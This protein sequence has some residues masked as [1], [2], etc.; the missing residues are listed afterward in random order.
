MIDQDKLTDAVDFVLGHNFSAQAQYYSQ[1][2]TH[3]DIPSVC[4][5]GKRGNRDR[6]W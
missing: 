4:P 3:R 6:L 5:P 2:R 1:R